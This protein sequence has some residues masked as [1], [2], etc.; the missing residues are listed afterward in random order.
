VIPATGA[1]GE[2]HVD[3]SE[4]RSKVDLVLS[5]SRYRE[6]AGAIAEQMKQ[7]GGARAAAERIEEFLSAGRP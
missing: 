4:L 1:D 5:E 3:A 7:F 2:K 6:S